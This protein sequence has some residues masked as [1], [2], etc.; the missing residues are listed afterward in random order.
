[1]AV[2]TPGSP[3]SM[4]AK[5]RPGLPTVAIL[6]WSW[7]ALWIASR[8][9]N[10]KNRFASMPS[11]RAPL[12][13]IS[14]GYTPSREPLEMTIETFSMLSAIVM[15]PFSDAAAR[16]GN[17]GDAG[18]DLRRALG[19]QLVQLLDRDTGGLAENPHRRAGALGEVLGAHEADDLPVGV[20]QPVDAFAPG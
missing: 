3:P 13:M 19:K 14:P 1:M 5:C 11:A 17:A 18:G 16:L 15:C 10:V 4:V 2:D 6:M 9:K 7:R 12:A 8:P 20:G